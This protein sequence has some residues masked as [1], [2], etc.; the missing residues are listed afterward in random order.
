MNGL[1]GEAKKFYKIETWLVGAK[2]I[3]KSELKIHRPSQRKLYFIVCPRSLKNIGSILGLE[4]GGGAYIENGHNFFKW[5]I[6]LKAH[7]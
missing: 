6:E 5:F 2:R 4:F 1:T 3:N 7:A